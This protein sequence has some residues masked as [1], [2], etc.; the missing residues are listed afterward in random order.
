MLNEKS[1]FGAKYAS[2]VSDI[3][4]KVLTDAP[5]SYQIRAVN[6]VCKKV[7]PF[8]KIPNAIPLIFHLLINS[9]PNF[10]IMESIFK[11]I[12]NENVEYQAFYSQL[13][14]ITTYEAFSERKYSE[15]MRLFS[16]FL[17]SDK[18]PSSYAAHFIKKLISLSLFSSSEVVLFSLALMEEM[19]EN[20]PSLKSMIQ[21]EGCSF[22]RFAVQDRL[23]EESYI[24]PLYEFL[25]LEKLFYACL[26]KFPNFTGGNKSVNAVTLFFDYLENSDHYHLIFEELNKTTVRS[27]PLSGTIPPTLI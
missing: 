27:C 17:S 24:P 9:V 7:L 5:S 14:K 25:L 13:S 2:L 3:W 12:I 15:N 11:L 4:R 16:T 6:Y 20:I 23:E 10:Q 18:L 1:E 22:E 26:I 21:N 19:F 8:V